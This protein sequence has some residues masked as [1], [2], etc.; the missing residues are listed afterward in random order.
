MLFA[1]VLKIIFRELLCISGFD[2]SFIKF[3]N[4]HSFQLQ[5][6]WHAAYPRRSIPNTGGKPRRHR[7]WLQPNLLGH[8]AGLLHIQNPHDRRERRP[9]S[10]RPQHPIPLRTKSLLRYLRRHHLL[11]IWRTVQSDACKDLPNIWAEKWGKSLQLR[12]LWVF[13]WVYF[14]VSAALLFGGELEGEGMGYKLF[15]IGRISGRGVGYVV[16]CQ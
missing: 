10:H 4:V 8:S 14:A 6:V 11:F 2:R 9:A 13:D 1:N 7:Q 3:R 16:L 5:G 15:Y 12:F